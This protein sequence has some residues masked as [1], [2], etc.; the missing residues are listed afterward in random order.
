MNRCFA[1]LLLLTALARGG[2]NILPN[3]DFDEGED[4]A[5]HWEEPN[6][7]TSRWVHEEGRGRILEMDTRVNKEQARA[8]DL[9]RKE[10]PT[11]PVPEKQLVGEPGYDSIGGSDGVMLDSEYLECKPGEHF[12]LVADIRG[13]G[14]AVVWIKGFLF[15]RRWRDAYQTRLVAY[16]ATEDQWRRYEILFE[17][18]QHSPKVTRFKVRCYAYWPNGIYYFDR[19]RVERVEDAEE[20]ARLL[21]ERELPEEERAVIAAE[22]VKQTAD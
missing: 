17:P 2:E 7:L 12:K 22:R 10:D 18:T 19:I 4:T 21:A 20:I 8:W 6:R 5:A 14:A 3:G 16:G 1:I 11:A 13:P 15:H 9:K